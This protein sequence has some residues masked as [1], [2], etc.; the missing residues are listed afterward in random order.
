MSSYEDRQHSE[1]RNLTRSCEGEGVRTLQKEHLCV[2][3]SGE[4][5]NI[6]GAD[7]GIL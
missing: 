7:L 5:T 1:I 4:D 6:T 2:K 3:L